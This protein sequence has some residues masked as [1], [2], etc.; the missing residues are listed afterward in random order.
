MPNLLIKNILKFSK[1]SYNNIHLESNSVS[2]ILPC[3]NEEKILRKALNKINKI[4]L[5][6]KN[7]FLEF[8]FVDGGSKDNSLKIAKSFKKLKI[9]SLKNKGRGYAINYGIKKAK[10]DVIA[11]FP[12]DNEYEVSD[13]EIMI[14]NIINSKEKIIYGS[15][16]IKC[17]NLSNQIKK[18]YKNNYFGYIISK[19]GGLLVSILMLLLYNRF[20]SDP[21]TTVKVFNAKIIKNLKINSS[22]VD[23][24]ME[25][26]VKLIKKNIY[27]NEYPVK[28]IGRNFNNGKKITIK[29]GL[30]CVYTLLKYKI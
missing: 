2:I 5:S 15:R 22:G 23:Y 9:Y 19:Y 3:L 24:D 21:F 27:I 12:T 20:I 26:C 10:G 30:S 6:N 1:K 4:Y 17:T 7:I 11:V 29:D 28:F 25:Q 16:L 14:K 18:V 8:I 13:L